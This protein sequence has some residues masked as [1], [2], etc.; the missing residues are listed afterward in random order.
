MIVVSLLLLSFYSKI[1]VQSKCGKMCL[2][3]IFIYGMFEKKLVNNISP[4]QDACYIKFT[5]VII[6]FSAHFHCYS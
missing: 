4:R 1:N 6:V 5:R 3:L 2:Q